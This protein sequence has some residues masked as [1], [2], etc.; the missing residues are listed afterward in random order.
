LPLS[1]VLLSG[2]YTQFATLDR[3]QQA[4]AQPK[5]EIIVD[6]TGDTVKV[7]REKDTVLITD[8]RVSYWERDMFGRPRLRVYNNYYDT[9]WY[10]YS[11]RPW[12]SDSYYY[13]DYY[14]PYSS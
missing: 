12:W 4:P 1:V 9:D 2:C 13:S 10:S 8:R 11:Y 3:Y 6:S 5:E 14:Y 7:V